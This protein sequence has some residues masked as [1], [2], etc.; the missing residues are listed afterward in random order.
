[1]EFFLLTVRSAFRNRLRSILTA[2]GV[3][4]A[5]IAFLF[6]RSFVSAWTSG[7]D[8]ASADR[9]VVRNKI[10]IIF[11]L[12]M[13]YLQKIKSVPGVADATWA[14]WF[15]GVYIDQR[16]FFAQ[17][18]VDPESYLRVYPE[19][20]LTPEEKQAWL[21]DRTGCIVGP[22]LAE[23]YGWKIG[24]QIPLQ[25]TIY[26]GDWKF[27]VRGIYSAGT[28]N[29]DLKTMLFQWKY[30]DE[31]MPEARKNNLGVVMIK[32]DDPKKGNDVAQ[33]I[34]GLFANSLAETR[35]ETEKAFQ[36]SFLSM[37][38]TVIVAIQLIS[39][40][41]LLILIL[42]LGN[43]VAMGTR[44]R[45]VE[46]A[47]MRAIGFKPGHIVTM[48]LGEGLVIG[49]F[50]G[51]LAVLMAPAILE[52]LGNAFKKVMGNFLGS[53]GIDRGGVVIALVAAL[54]GGAVAAAV[55][56]WLAGRRKLVDALRRVE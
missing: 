1:M 21:A 42:I 7:Y 19:I 18:A 9:L 24:D 13:S 45:T 46:Y 39:L 51:L 48:V 44:E 11:P 40:V 23:K 12:P 22:E 50:G 49:G 14:N 56:A 26:P 31:S 41:V 15:G 27:T 6:L 33:A 10:S 20:Q 38:S 2:V 43:T 25:G 16:N 8:R 34:D 55:P 37:V 28:K 30:L 47:M 5:I 36:L 53:F 4:I 3:A 52:G 54:A 32:V 29:A 35:T 17:F